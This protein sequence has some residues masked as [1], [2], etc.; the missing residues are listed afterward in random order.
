MKMCEK[1]A[2]VMKQEFE[3]SMLGELSYF[4]GLQV[5]QNKSGIFLSQQKYAGEMLKKF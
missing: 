1:F 2:T 3:M 4:L 5:H